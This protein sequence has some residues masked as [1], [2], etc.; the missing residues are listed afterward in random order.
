MAKSFI[1]A[2][3]CWPHARSIAYAGR[4]R[5]FYTD[6]QGVVARLAAKNGFAP[7]PPIVSEKVLP[8]LLKSI[9]WQG[10]PVALPE[11]KPSLTVV[12]PVW[13]SSAFEQLGIIY[14]QDPHSNAETSY[15]VVKDGSSGD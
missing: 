10:V 1:F 2:T 14:E 13:L 5:W 4:E 11:P 15:A 3:A 9:R 8:F 7:L 6:E 12:G